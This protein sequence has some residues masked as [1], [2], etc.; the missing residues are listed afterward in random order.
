MADILT[1]AQARSAL[2]WKAAS[3]TSDEAELTA[4][5]IPAVTQ[6]IENVCGR[7]ADRRESWRTDDVAPLTTPWAAA[8][9]KAVTVGS[10]KLAGWTFTAPTLTITDSYYT[11][12]DE[13]TVVAGGLPTPATILLVARRV[14]ASTWNADHQG[15]GGAR[16][17]GSASV[18]VA[19][20][21]R[22]FDEL[23]PYRIVGG[24]A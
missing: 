8:T 18:T 4:L 19:L 9:I 13:V 23:E 3:H 5:Y 22:D 2:G 21:P 12:G 20:S 1:L 7:M 6:A 11:A 16:P 24:F 14:L 17:D 10:Y 15:T